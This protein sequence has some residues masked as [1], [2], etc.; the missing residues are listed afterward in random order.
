MLDLHRELIDCRI[1]LSIIVGPSC[2]CCCVVI[3]RLDNHDCYHGYMLDLHWDLKTM[4]RLTVSLTVVYAIDTVYPVHVVLLTYII[5]STML[6][7]NVRNL[8]HWS[9]RLSWLYICLSLDLHWDLKTMNR[10]LGSCIR[11]LRLLK[12]IIDHRLSHT[13]YITIN[14]RL[15]LLIEKND[16][17]AISLTPIA[18]LISIICLLL[19]YIICMYHYLY[20]YIYWF[21]MRWKQ[22]KLLKNLSFS[23]LLL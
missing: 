11:A 15:F 12:L 19:F 8:I 1:S 5:G 2:L 3:N 14:Y 6:L 9:F 17:G 22:I 7:E 20:W 21:V 16:L 4:N 10:F 23:F 13:Y 18:F